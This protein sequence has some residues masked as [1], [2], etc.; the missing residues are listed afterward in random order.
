MRFKKFKILN[1]SLEELVESN[2]ALKY[3]K[4]GL[5]RGVVYKIPHNIPIN[6]I[7]NFRRNLLISLSYKDPAYTQRKYHCPN[8]Y[9][10]HWDNEHQHIKGKFISWSYYSWNKESFKLF[11]EF[12]NLYV[13]RN[14]L[15]G[16]EPTK[17]IDNKSRNFAARIAA[18]FYPSGAGYLDEHVDPLNIHQFALPTLLLSKP[19]FDF[20]S[21][22][23]Y[24]LGSN[25]ETFFLDKRLN[26]GDLFLFHTSIPHGVKTIDKDLDFCK[27]KKKGRL[28]MIA[29]V[30]ALTNQSSFQSTKKNE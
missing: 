30:N 8:D 7:K 20:N 22:G 10:V 13:L 21:G 11:K 28:M 12:K 5:A 6:F 17:Y 25:D 2:I 3:L 4:F 1:I 19:G 23:F 16:L 24:L 27:S 9:R 14:K 26:F 29:A 15:A 18:Q